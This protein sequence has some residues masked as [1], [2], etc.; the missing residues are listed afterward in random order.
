MK[1][2]LIIPVYNVE[3][4][5]D[6]CL[7]SVIN[8]TYNNYE[9]IIVN[10]GTLDNSQNIIDAYVNKDKRF[11]S[12]IKKNGGLSDARNYGLNHATGD[13]IVFIDSDDYIDKDYLKNISA[14]LKKFKNIDVLK[15]KLIIV[16]EHGN[17][18]RREKG[19]Y[20]NGYVD[21]EKLVSLEFFEPA[22]SY[23]YSFKFWKDNR[24]EYPKDKI[25]EDFGL[26]PEILIKAK[27]IYYLNYYSYYY[28]TRENSIM[29]SNSRE[30][31]L[32]KAYDMLYH[33]DRLIDLN[34][35]DIPE[36]SIKIYKS[37]LSNGLISKIK[38][39]E[40]KDTKNYI[41]EL[42]KRNVVSNIMDDSFIRKIKKIILRL[43]YRMW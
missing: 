43:K 7:N 41:Q 21:F 42:K 29:T 22:W 24:F 23:V 37:F 35:C 26:T 28:V 11:K 16:D 9:A 32:K 12:F 2:S 30:K 33:Y 15:T 13:Y 25:H 17:E 20:E 36:R 4:Y 6:K 3:K 40:T 14:V 1:F 31:N 39:L 10:D 18:I 34:L 5:I 19:F 27:K 8:Q 38:T